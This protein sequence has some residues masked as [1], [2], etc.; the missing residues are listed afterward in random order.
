MIS[1]G[2]IQYRWA[3]ITDRHAEIVAEIAVPGRNPI[4]LR[5]DA[6]GV[7]IAVSL[8]DI[9]MAESHDTTIRLANDRTALEARARIDHAR[10]PR[11]WASH[12]ANDERTTV[13]IEPQVTGG[14]VLNP[15]GVDVPVRRH[16]VSTDIPA[17]ISV[18]QGPSKE[19][20][21]R[22]V[23]AL[24][25]VEAEWIDVDPETTEMAIEATIRNG[26]PMALP[27][28]DLRYRIA[29]N[30]VVVGTGRSRAT[31]IPSKATTTVDTTAR[32][33]NETMREWWPRHLRRG[34]VTRI[35]VDLYATLDAFGST[36]EIH[37]RYSDTFTT[38]LLSHE[39]G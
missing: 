27:F 11:W 32:F 1:P 31:R 17:A 2:R 22:T 25:G 8:N 6:L 21:G 4:E 10:V 29:M 3:E 24:D 34:E 15:L 5:I 18:D 30:D 23:V 37:H 28:D 16:T 35:D 19:F 26:L 38:D 12:V 13:V 9:A 14:N 20:M 7:D 33:D 39:R 36:R